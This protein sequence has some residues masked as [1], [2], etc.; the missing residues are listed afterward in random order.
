MTE[1][2]IHSYSLSDICEQ[3]LRAND[4]A[5]HTVPSPG[6]YPHQWLWDSC[7]SAIGWSHI[8]TERAKTEIF[9]LLKGQWRNGMIPHM[10]FESSPKYARD[11]NV[12]RSWISRN[13]PDNVSTSGITQPPVIAEAV[14]RIGQQL[15]KSDRISFYK[16]MLPKIVKYHEWLYTDRD[17]HNEGL[18]LQ[19]SPYETGLDNTP[20]WMNQL[21]E[22]SRPAWIAVIEN[23]K[24]EKFINVVRRDVREVPAEQ[25]MK[26]IDALMTWDA[27]LRL[28][29]KHYDIDKI[30]HRS[31]FAIEDVSFNSIFVRNNTIL[32]DIAKESRIKLPKELTE[33][34]K[35]SEISLEELWDEQFSLYLSRDFITNKL[36]KEPT[37]ASLMP[38]YAGTIS[39]DRADKLVK[40]LSSSNSFWLKFPVP[41]VPRNF[42]GFEANRYW[43][44]PTWINTNWLLIDGLN[45]MGYENEANALK[46]HTLDM[47]RE[48]GVWEYYNPNT[49]KGLGS[50]DFSWS[51]ALGLDLLNT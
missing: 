43:Q 17:P 51:A 34:M 18:V 8:D 48:N 37:I 24:L 46:S 50:R 42:R 12:W 21:R 28:R 7:F 36:L 29:R 3:V 33:K 13:S 44:G 14:W 15:S 25:R 5:T 45:R 47:M 49:G 11:R 16:K 4:R 26:N 19:I 41:T 39:K 6:L 32:R 35:L 23:L 30:L 22:H 1:D 10:I 31:L 38:L 40:I 2:E 20:P 27:V 9:S